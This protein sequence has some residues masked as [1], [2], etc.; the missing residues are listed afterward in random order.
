MNVPFT[1][2]QFMGVFAAYNTA[3][4]PLQ[5]AL[6]AVAVGLIVATCFPHTPWLRRAAAIVLAVLWAWSG[7]VYHA[8]HFAP[9]NP[10][11][12][13]F[14]AAFVLQALLYAYY[15]GVRGRTW[16]G[17]RQAGWLW[18]AGWTLVIYA[19][20]VYPLLGVL[21]GHHYPHRPTF[22]LPCPLTLFSIGLAAL[23]RPR[24]PR[25]VL[26]IPVLWAALGSTAAFTMG[27][28]QDL[29]LVPAAAL[30][31]FLLTIGGKGDSGAAEYTPTDT[32]RRRKDRARPD[33]PEPP[34]L[35]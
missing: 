31:L 3:V 17:G 33:P 10:T 11:A 19:L 6:V 9:V 18:A 12:R 7:I 23:S 22:G 30:G 20:A 16:F 8:L 32:N 5:L 34:V 14:G 25:A 27:I 24:H 35:Y 15:G 2:Q 28:W 26:V 29:A 21:L 1:E 4:W 13:L